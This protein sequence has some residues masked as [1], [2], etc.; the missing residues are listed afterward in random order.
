MFQFTHTNYCTFKLG[1]TSLHFTYLVALMELYRS[2]TPVGN[3]HS[4]SISPRKQTP[5]T[6]VS[7]FTACHGMNDMC[8]KVLQLSDY[9]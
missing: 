7:T 6:T 5:V 4:L 9:K 3:H 1:S 2:Q 8:G